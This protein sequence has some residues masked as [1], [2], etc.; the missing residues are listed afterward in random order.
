MQTLNKNNTP[1][2][3]YSTYRERHA[4]RVV[5]VKDQRVLLIRSHKYNTY[6]LPGGGVEDG[7]SLEQAAIREV[8]EETGLEVS[9][10]GNVGMTTEVFD[11]RSILNVTTCFSA[12]VESEREHA[13]DQES[14]EEGQELLWVPLREAVDLIESVHKDAPHSSMLRDAFFLQ[15]YLR[16]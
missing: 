4:V 3:V 13:L 11:E 8:M 7:E 14:V 9:I 16:S 2:S 12:R 10:V 15:Q 5:I 1:E 6:T